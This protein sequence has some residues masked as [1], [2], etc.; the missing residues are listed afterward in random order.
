MKYVTFILSLVCSFMFSTCLVAQWQQLNMPTGV[1]L[2]HVTLKGDTLIPSFTGN[3]LPIVFSGR[4]AADGHLWYSTSYGLDWDTIHNKPFQ[5]GY[6]H[7]NSKSKILYAL[8]RDSSNNDFAYQSKDGGATWQKKGSVGNLRHI[9]RILF[10][11]DT[12]YLISNYRPYRL[13]TALFVLPEQHPLYYFNDIGYA[14][15]QLLA[16]TPDGIVQSSDRG[17]T[18]KFLFQDQRWSSVHSFNHVIYI[19]KEV[20]YVSTDTTFGLYRSE[21]GGITRKQVMQYS[22]DKIFRMLQNTNGRLYALRS[23]GTYYSDDNGFTWNLL[24]YVIN[25]LMWASGDTLIGQ[26]RYSFDEGAHWETMTTARELNRTMPTRFLSASEQTLLIPGYYSNNNGRTFQDSYITKQATRMQ[27]YGNLAFAVNGETSLKPDNLQSLMIS[28]DAGRNW[29]SLEGIVDTGEYCT[30]FAYHPIWNDLYL[31]IQNH[32]RDTARIYRY[33]LEER[34][35]QEVFKLRFSPPYI[36]V[37]DS[38]VMLVKNSDRKEVDLT[39]DRGNTWQNPLL[40]FPASVDISNAFGAGKYIAFYYNF[41]GLLISDNYGRSWQSIGR[42]P[43]INSFISHGDILFQALLLSR[44]LE[45]YLTDKYGI[46]VL[47]WMAEKLGFL[48]V[49]DYLIN[50]RYFQQ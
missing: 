40:S 24:P 18:W 12:I 29:R 10:V 27:A 46:F 25:D 45:T 31:T 22:N 6:F 21:D 8:G 13:D 32:K 2:Q 28:E 16:T 36:V 33:N 20:N 49:K 37:A 41:Y 3:M 35:K 17:E 42:L 50:C 11:E 4:E 15:G 9:Q 1:A 7:F 19:C 30:D 38:A 44:E 34:V 23:S 48:S 43:N 39:R 26:L 14:N 5:G 47:L